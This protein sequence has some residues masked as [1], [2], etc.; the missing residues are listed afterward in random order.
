MCRSCSPGHQRLLCLERCWR[1]GSLLGRA[2][3]GAGAGELLPGSRGEG[4]G[5]GATAMAS[6][7]VVVSNSSW[8]VTGWEAVWKSFLKVTCVV[9]FCFSLSPSSFLPLSSPTPLSPQAEA[10]LWVPLSFPPTHLAAK[11]KLS[12]AQLSCF[13]LLRLSSCP[14]MA[15]EECRD[16]HPSPCNITLGKEKQHKPWMHIHHC[17]GCFSCL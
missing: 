14:A 10:Q 7:L 1:A 17:L 5:D 3:A 12:V 8:V 9:L 11:T 16:A 2:E 4:E 15:I 13:L 6:A